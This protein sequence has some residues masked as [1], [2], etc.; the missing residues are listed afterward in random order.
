MIKEKVFFIQCINTV[1]WNTFLFY[2]ISY[3]NVI[4]GLIGPVGKLNLLLNVFWTEKRCYKVLTLANPYVEFSMRCD[5]NVALSTWSFWVYVLMSVGSGKTPLFVNGLQCTLLHV[6]DLISSL[7]LLWDCQTDTTKLCCS[8]M[9]IPPPLF[10][11]PFH[12]SD[13]LQYFFSLY[14]V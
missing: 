7:F 14:Q 10:F 4:C 6:T 11:S 8:T 1:F 12:S 5:M 3:Y 2:F 9:F 13:C